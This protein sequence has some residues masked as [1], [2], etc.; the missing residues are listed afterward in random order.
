MGIQVAY[1]VLACPEPL[2]AAN[3]ATLHQFS[4]TLACIFSSAFQKA[5]VPPLF[6]LIIVILPVPCDV[7]RTIPRIC[8]LFLLLLL[9]PLIKV[10]TKGT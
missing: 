7:A 5:G 8:F 1:F 3:T 4:L 2:Q 10:Y 6:F 9:L